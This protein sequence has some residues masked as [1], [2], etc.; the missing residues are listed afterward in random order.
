MPPYP[1]Q[2]IPALI[3]AQSGPQVDGRAPALARHP[4]VRPLRQAHV[5]DLDHWYAWPGWIMVSK[6]PTNGDDAI[7]L[8][9]ASQ[10]RV[11][12]KGR[13]SPAAPVRP[14]PVRGPDVPA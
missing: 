12:V 5:A 11:D 1:E 9:H 4:G 6:L 7:T 3:R 13:R 2:G 8:H 10:A 14:R